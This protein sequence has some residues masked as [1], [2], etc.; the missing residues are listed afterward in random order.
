MVLLCGVTLLVSV[1]SLMAVSAEYDSVIYVDPEYGRVD[2]SCWTGGVDV[3]CKTVELA[4]EGARRVSTSVSPV[5]LVQPKCPTA[6]RSSKD[7]TAFRNAS[8]NVY[9]SA[10]S[11]PTWQHRNETGECVCG[12]TLHDVVNCDDKFNDTSV[13]SC[14]CMTFSDEHKTTVLGKCYY[15]CFRFTGENKKYSYVRYDVP[16]N[17]SKLN[18]A[19]CGRYSRTGQLCGNCIEGYTPLAYSYELRC[20][21]CTGSAVS[22]WMKYLAAAFLPLT[23]FYIIVIVFK[24]RATAPQLYGFVVYSQAMS[25]PSVVRNLVTEVSSRPVLSKF[26]KAGLTLAGVW[27]LDFFRTILPDICLDLNSFQLLLLEYAVSF[28]PLLLILISYCMI[29]L[30]DRG[31][32]VVVLLWKPFV[33]FF[34]FVR[35]DWDIRTA[36]I[37]TF[38]TFLLLSYMRVICISFYLLA[39]V[40]IHDV[41]GRTVGWFLYSNSSVLFFS[42]EHLPYGIV[43]LVVTVFCSIF[44]ALLMILYPMVCFQRLLNRL[45]LRTPT[46]HTFMDYFQGYY[47]D[48]TDSAHDCRYFSGLYLLARFV[49]YATYGVSFDM[50]SFAIGTILLILVSFM[51][52][53]IKPYK[54]HL[55]MYNTVDACIM[56]ILAMW[57]ASVLAVNIAQIKDHNFVVSSYWLSLVV[58]I[59]P[60]IYM[61]VFSG[62]W[63]FRR[64]GFGRTLIWKARLRFGSGYIMLQEPFEELPHRINNPDF[65]VSFPGSFQQSD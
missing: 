16:N 51:V 7:I 3:P 54:K 8:P 52:I 35:S 61:S 44:P 45:R 59:S 31:F 33:K 27:N 5:V 37:H 46:L 64:D 17:V 56:L 14:Y 38:A 41:T 48:R 18:D 25:T 19:M 63:I 6:A 9:D 10:D 29:D 42:K 49:F 57:L 39:P 13:L 12:A 47:K 65:S 62:Y 50:Y 15:G 2:N 11:C 23:G 34:T 20:M 24:I 40:K 22:N 4:L 36:I 28:Y 30:H 55:S 1:A 26:V 53:I 32:K 43:A 21:N 58:A 60:M